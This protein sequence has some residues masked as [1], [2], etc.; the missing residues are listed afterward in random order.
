MVWLNVNFRRV[1]LILS[2]VGLI[3]SLFPTI[4]YSFAFWGVSLDPARNNAAYV[5]YQ[6]PYSPAGRSGLYRGD[7]IID[8]D[9]FYAILDKLKSIKPHETK[10][11]QVFRNKQFIE[12]NLT[13]ERSIVADVWYTNQISTVTGFLMLIFL[14]FGLFTRVPGSIQRWA[15]GPIIVVLLL[16]AIRMCVVIAEAGRT[17]HFSLY[18]GGAPSASEGSFGQDFFV[19]AALIALCVL[20]SIK[21]TTVLRAAKSSRLTTSD[22]R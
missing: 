21:L 15:L 10:T 19:A 12:V 2:L 22:A 8:P 6:N 20:L 16:L 4:S 11:F 18:W 5:S 3:A 17:S 14:V 13:G 9:G 7:V 1:F